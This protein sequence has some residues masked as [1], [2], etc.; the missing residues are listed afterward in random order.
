MAVLRR[1][2]PVA[3]FTCGRFLSRCTSR[4]SLARLTLLFHPLPLHHSATSQY[5]QRNRAFWEKFPGKLFLSLL[6]ATLRR[7][8]STSHSDSRYRQRARWGLFRVV[9]REWARTRR[10]SLT[11]CVTAWKNIYITARYWSRS[12][13]HSFV[14]SVVKVNRTSDSGRVPTQFQAKCFWNLEITEISI[15]VNQTDNLFLLSDLTV[16]AISI[17]LLLYGRTVYTPK[18]QK[19]DTY[20]KWNKFVRK[21]L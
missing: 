3:G 19:Y 17:L 10:G 8:Y 1:F 4:T 15:F 12:T 18:S 20:R 7:F 5:T 13:T 14:R 9:V 11:F 2:L 16:R 21:L 6:R